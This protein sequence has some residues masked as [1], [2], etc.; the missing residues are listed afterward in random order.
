MVAR[1][2]GQR[3]LFNS[4]IA[5]GTPTAFLT[6]LGRLL[7]PLAPGR[8]GI[9]GLLAE[10][11][12]S[13]LFHVL[14]NALT[15]LLLLLLA[16]RLGL[17]WGGQGALLFYLTF[18]PTLREMGSLAHLESFLTLSIPVGL[19]LFGLSH[20]HK[21]MLLSVASGVVFG[22]AFANRI[23]GGVVVIAALAYVGLRLLFRPEASESVWDSLWRD[24]VRLGLLCLVGWAVF[25]LC[26]P[27]LWRSPLFG[28]VD[29]LYQQVAL[30]GA[31]PN[32]RAPALFLWTHSNLTFLFLVLTLAGLFLKPVRSSRV[33]QLGLLL[34]LFGVL[35]VSL[36][37]RFYPRYL[38]SALPGLGLAG[39]CT[40][41]YA[42][43]GRRKYSIH[44]TRLAI[45]ALLLLTTWFAIS[46][47]TRHWDGFQQIRE[48]YGELNSQNFA[49]IEVPSFGSFFYRPGATS[50]DRILLVRTS[51][52]HSRLFYLDVLLTD[53]RWIHHLRGRWTH[54]RLEKRS[55]CSEGNWMLA[56]L[57][58]RNFRN[59]NAIRLGGAIAWPCG[60]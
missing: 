16:R 9:D 53:L 30:T 11:V 29:F 60:E 46:I 22:L 5:T 35:I 6:G 54:Q 45:G 3:R 25:I 34:L 57:S 26:F 51:N 1:M 7:I 42:L 13:R 10:V 56:N 28:F 8:E 32:F 2:E 44:L 27:P 43:E 59:E 31:G 14:S 47:S 36:P 33:F 52:D 19:L 24:G 4:Y 50:G 48:F 18:D 49:R 58:P 39:S 37:E 12:L 17:A 15:P 21:S 40:V 41:A 20:L 38:A 23:N 55:A